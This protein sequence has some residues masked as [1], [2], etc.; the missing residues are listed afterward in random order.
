MMTVPP[1][2]NVDHLHFVISDPKKGTYVVVNVTSDQLRAG[3]DCVLQ[4]GEHRRI[5]KES[6]VNFVDALEITP[7]IARNLEGLIGKLIGMERPMS[8]ALL[9]KI[10][11][12]GKATKNLQENLKSLL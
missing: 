8:P 2:F 11:A 1:K 6:F 9:S 10:V 3:K 4:A 12:A 7:E 5:T